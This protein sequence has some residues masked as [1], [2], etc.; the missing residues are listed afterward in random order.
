MSTNGQGYMQSYLRSRRE[1]LEMGVRQA[2]ATITNDERRFEAERTYYRDMVGS[3]DKQVLEYDKMLSKLAQERQKLTRPLTSRRTSSSGRESLMGDDIARAAKTFTE[4]VDGAA[5]GSRFATET[6]AA[7]MNVMTDTA[8][9]MMQDKVNLADRQKLADELKGKILLDPQF[10]SLPVGARAAVIDDMTNMIG[11]LVTEKGGGFAI[12]AE[13]YLPKDKLG[14]VSAEN[15]KKAYDEEFASRRGPEAEA[16]RDL[17]YSTLKARGPFLGGG[18][19][20]TTRSELAPGERERLDKINSEGFRAT[21]AFI[22][23][24]GELSDDERAKLAEAKIDPDEY[25]DMALMRS[26]ARAGVL[27]AERGSLVGRRSAAQA[28]L[29]AMVAPDTSDQRRR[30]LTAMTYGPAG[31][32]PTQALFTPG[33]VE[34]RA[35][36][37]RKEL[38]AKQAMLKGVMRAAA[39]DVPEMGEDD[40]VYAS[41]LSDAVQNGNVPAIRETYDL[42]KQAG[43]SDERLTSSFAVASSRARQL[44]TRREAQA[45][46]AAAPE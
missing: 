9:K 12:N 36:A 23:D 42:M 39:G 37:Q 19:S 40:N 20:S 11:P 4:Q 17:M 27:T 2:T 7:I 35:E 22:R 31:V 14:L 5:L 30:E 41:Q 33:K 8:E 21:A 43:Y 3:L 32:T 18:T 46:Q 13:L 15:R 25:L 1:L 6:P 28:D 10:R 44:K 24:D 16:G 26:I 34:E 29:E 38:T 45:A